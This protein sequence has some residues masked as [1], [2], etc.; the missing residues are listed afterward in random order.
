MSATSVQ[1]GST[2][3]ANAW[4]SLAFDEW[5][6]TCATLHLWTQVIGKI[7]LE[8]APMVNH[9]WQVTLYVTATGLTTSA[10]PY[11]SRLLQIDFDFLEHRLILRTSD[12]RIE[13]LGLVPRSVADFHAEVMQRL[14]ALGVDVHIWTMP[15][16]I[17]NA[18]PFERDR[19]HAAY[20]RD[21]AERFW[22]QLVQADRVM[23]VFRG[24]YLGKCSPVH[25]FWGSF[26]L[27]VT[28]FSGRTAPPLTSHS[29]NL[30]D[31]VMREAYSH[32]VSSCGF[33]PGNG[34]LGYPAFYVYAYPEPAGF[35]AA[36]VPPPAAYNTDLGQ[37]IL[38]YDAVRTAD[39]P[40]DLLL[41]FLQSTYEACADRAHW[42]RH[43][44][45]R[46]PLTK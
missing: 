36:P 27:A 46:E 11:Q 44:L 45:E 22:R 32:E 1:T 33:W 12:G 18:I 8:L 28:R 16:E 35:G 34:G 5:K 14:R 15:S 2:G 20:D 30:G 21:A 29:P 40:D 6:D 23:N 31:W 37:F 42:D 39:V 43:A 17:E 25:F 26:D 10:M 9:W 4:P 7:R 19:E 41:Q 24:R 13:S 38:P 3:G